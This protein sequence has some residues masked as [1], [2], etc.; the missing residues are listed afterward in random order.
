MKYL[1]ILALVILAGCNSEARE[2]PN[3]SLVTFEELQRAKP[4][5]SNRKI[6]QARLRETIKYYNLGGDPDTMDE[7]TRAFNSV[8]KSTLWWYEA[9]CNED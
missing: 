8:L 5:C 1:A 7:S 4:T 6:Q 9:N 2:N 3:S